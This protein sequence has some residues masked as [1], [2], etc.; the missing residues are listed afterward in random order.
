MEKLLAGA[1]G[2][3]AKGGMSRTGSLLTGSLG[4]HVGRCRVLQEGLSAERQLVLNAAHDN[5]REE[6]ACPSHLTVYE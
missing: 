3:I 6:I 5:I 1:A 4:Y 2:W